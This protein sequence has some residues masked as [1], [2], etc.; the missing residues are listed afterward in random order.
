MVGP[1]VVGLSPLQA[2]G[3][4]KRPG[5]SSCRQWAPSPCCSFIPPHPQVSFIIHFW[6]PVFDTCV[7]EQNKGKEGEV[8]APFLC[9]GEWAVEPSEWMRLALYPQGVKSPG[10]PAKFG[11]CAQGPCSAKLQNVQCLF[12]KLPD[13]LW[14]PRDSAKAIGR[15]FPSGN[16]SVW[17]PVTP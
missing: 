5:N 4:T 3:C 1:I 13:L 6:G 15:V 12:K 7:R 16:H 10:F 17:R 2:L 11:C 9:H 14:P 8:Q